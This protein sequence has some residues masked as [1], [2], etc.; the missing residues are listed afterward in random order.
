[1]SEGALRRYVRDGLGRCGVLS[2]HHEDSLNV[3]LPDLSYSGNR[4][5]G[6]IELKWAESWPKRAETPLRLPHYT[7]EQ[8]H[9][10][11]ARARAGGGRCW[12]LLRVGREHLLFN[13]EQ[14]QEVGELE[15]AELLAR[16]TMHTDRGRID[17]DL[18]TRILT[19]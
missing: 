5:H 11:L 13:H 19:K 14:A 10:L 12:L 3:G 1:M 8:K 4:V 9:F 18:L 16:A 17:F 7:K 2:T 15:R 6:W